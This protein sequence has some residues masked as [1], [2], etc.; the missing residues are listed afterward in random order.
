MKTC[1][2][3][4]IFLLVILPLFIIGCAITDNPEAPQSQNPP[5]VPKSSGNSDVYTIPEQPV[6]KD[7][8]KIKQTTQNML[9][10]Q[11]ASSLEPGGDAIFMVTY[12]D[13]PVADAVILLDGVDVGTTDIMGKISIVLPFMSEIKLEAIKADLYGIEVCVITEESDC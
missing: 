8:T 7:D 6:I 5:V 12:K 4:G 2:R 10:I 11:P 1:I 3:L 13:N 9:V